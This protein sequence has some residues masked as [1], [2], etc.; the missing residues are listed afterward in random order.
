[1]TR[2]TEYTIVWSKLDNNV[3]L[4]RHSAKIETV[5]IKDDELF[6]LIM[7]YVPDGILEIDRLD[8]ANVIYNIVEANEEHR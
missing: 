3:T 5:G 8:G 1:M 2:R 7:D 6:N 4:Y